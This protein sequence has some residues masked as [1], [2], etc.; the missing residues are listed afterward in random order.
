VCVPADGRPLIQ[1]LTLP[2]GEKGDRKAVFPALNMA[3]RKTVRAAGVKTSYALVEV[4]VNDGAGSAA[5]ASFVATR[6]KVLDGSK[7]FGSWRASGR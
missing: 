2:V 4:E 7:E 5:G 1:N 6:M 3:D